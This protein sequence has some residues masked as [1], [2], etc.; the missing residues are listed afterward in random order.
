LGV[1][2]TITISNNRFVSTYVSGGDI[3]NGINLEPTGLSAYPRIITNNSFSGV[4]TN[5]IKIAGGQNWTIYWNNFSNTGVYI[6]QTNDSLVNYLNTSIGGVGEG[7]IYGNVVNGSVQ[8]I[9]SPTINSSYGTGWYVANNGTGHPYN[10]STSEGK[11]V[12]NVTDYAP[13]TQFH[14]EAPTT[15]ALIETQGGVPIWGSALIGKCAATSPIG[16][17]TVGIEWGWYN[18]STQIRN[19]TTTAL[20]DG[21]YKIMNNVSSSET[22]AGDI[23]LIRCRANNSEGFSEWAN[24]SILIRNPSTFYVSPSGNDTLGN[25][26]I[27]APWKTITYALSQ[28][29]PEDTLTL[30]DGTYVESAA[31][32]MPDGVFLNATDANVSSLGGAVFNLAGTG[33]TISGVSIDCS[34]GGATTG[35]TFTATSVNETVTNT[36]IKSCSIGASFNDSSTSGTITGSKFLNMS[37]YGATIQSGA[38]SSKIS[39]SV[40]YLTPTYAVYFYSGA[41]AGTGAI[42]ENNI[43]AESG[44]ATTSSIYANFLNGKSNNFSIIGNSFGTETDPIRANGIRF[45]N[46]ANRSVVHNNTF[47]FT[48][49]SN[50]RSAISASSFGVSDY[51][52]ITHNRIGS[53]NMPISSP[54]MSSAPI[55]INNGVGH[56]ISNNIIWQ[57]YGVIVGINVVGDVSAPSTGLELRDNEIHNTDE[58]NSASYLLGIGIEGG[59]HGHIINPQVTGNRLYSA[60]NSGSPN[61]G[62]FV[63][64]TDNPYIANN[65]VYNG[66]YSYVFKGNQNGSVYNNTGLGGRLG[67]YDKASQNIIYVDNYFAGSIGGNYPLYISQNPSDNRSANGSIWYNTALIQNGSLFATNIFGQSGARTETIMINTSVNG[68]PNST[69]IPSSYATLHMGW[70]YRARVTNTNTDT[71]IANATVLVQDGGNNT[72]WELT[73]GADGYTDSKYLIQYTLTN[74]TTTNK[75]TYNTT[76]FINGIE[77][78]RREF[79]ATTNVLNDTFYVM[80][81]AP[82]TSVPGGS[83]SIMPSLSYLFN[84]SSGALQVFA[85]A[86]GALI[87]G[88]TIH[89]KDPAQTG[90]LA[91]A[92]TDSSGIATFT[93]SQSMRYSAESLQTSSY[94]QSYLE[95]FTLTLCLFPLQNS[96]LPMPPGNLSMEPNITQPAIPHKT[97]QTIPLDKKQAAEQEI[98]QAKD[99]AEKAIKEGKEVNSAV[100]LISSAMREFDAGNYEK[101]AQLSQEALRLAMSS[102]PKAVADITTPAQQAPIG[103]ASA[104]KETA[105]PVAAFVMLLGGVAVVTAGVFA[106]LKW[107]GKKGL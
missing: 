91:S 39:S 106:Y 44:G 103:A 43:F 50:S 20:S 21:S 76:L 55:S 80:A 89:L 69:I 82:I 101:A 2:R 16:I 32:T 24:H 86:Q 51:L 47:F 13:L 83:G 58:T 65:F 14:A 98:K 81:D 37:L 99:A 63:G 73:T 74:E 102:K 36:S 72:V 11:M 62:L 77:I 15:F 19:G 7:N 33:S 67:F 66:A 85:K 49:T 42:I 75:T 9:S 93:I 87:S 23:W 97:N 60:S 17:E 10:N 68:E 53:E 22:S 95:P 70:Y 27:G 104:A 107:R 56:V 71:P 88:L 3:P 84:C 45:Y 90:Y 48:N 25:G 6:R 52:T 59:A 78:E 5:A 92:T 8:A 79:N 54:N 18:G 40:F 96:T 64:Y 12:G 34:L 28:I 105:L 26:S 30:M 61:H 4:Y 94:S 1:N 57:G 35:V 41:I 38:I 46:G 100:S 29:Y 31:I